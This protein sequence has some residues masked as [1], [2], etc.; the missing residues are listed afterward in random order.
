MQKRARRP[1]S[2][3]EKTNTK[4][5]SAKCQMPKD[6]SKKKTKKRNRN[7]QQHKT[8]QKQKQPNPERSEE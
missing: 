2:T 7:N 6:Q 4:M 1:I 8:K 5:P 3:N